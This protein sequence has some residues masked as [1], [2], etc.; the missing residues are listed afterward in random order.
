MT[1]KKRRE[2]RD[3]LGAAPPLRLGW[4]DH[5]RQAGFDPTR[6]GST[7]CQPAD[8][9]PIIAA[10]KPLIIAIACPLNP[11][12][13]EQPDPRWQIEGGNVAGHTEGKGG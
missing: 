2:V 9:R 4:P 5:D 1:G 11:D 10:G 12:P 8:A 7:K 3:I 6:R 13:E